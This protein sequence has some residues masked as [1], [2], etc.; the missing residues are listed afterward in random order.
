MTIGLILITALA[1]GA[2]WATGTTAP[3]E[4]TQLPDADLPDTSPPADA[5]LGCGPILPSCNSGDCSGAGCTVELNTC[6]FEDLGYQCC[7][8]NG[9]VLVCDRGQSVWSTTCDCGVGP[10]P[11]LC[12]ST[13]V[14]THYCS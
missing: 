9:T 1:A 10:Q 5:V 8:D 2:L 7:N 12:D 6:E 13:Q 3:V 4:D 14:K 11:G